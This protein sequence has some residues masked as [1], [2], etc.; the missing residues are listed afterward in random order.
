[1]TEWFC[2]FVI[3]VS[4]PLETKAESFEFFCFIS[5]FWLQ[6]TIQENYCHNTRAVLSCHSETSLAGDILWM[7]VCCEEEAT[8]K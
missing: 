3:Q 8:G 6:G 7:R 5:Q 1:M 4:Y 2:W